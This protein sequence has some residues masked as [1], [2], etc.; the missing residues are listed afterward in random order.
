MRH[1]ARTMSRPPSF[2]AT[3]AKCSYA[4]PEITFPQ[5]T[6]TGRSEKLPP[7][8]RCRDEASWEILAFAGEYVLPLNRRITAGTRVLVQ[9]DVD[10]S[11]AVRLYTVDGGETVIKKD[12]LLESELAFGVVAP[13]EKVKK[14][15]LVMYNSKNRR[16]TPSYK[17]PRYIEKILETTPPPFPAPCPRIH[18]TCFGCQ[19]TVSFEV[20]LGSLARARYAFPSGDCFP[21]QSGEKRRSNHVWKVTADAGLVLESPDREVLEVHGVF[22]DTIVVVRN[23]RTVES[24]DDLRSAVEIY[25]EM[26]K[27]KRHQCLD[28]ETC[29]RFCP[30]YHPWKRKHQLL[31]RLRHPERFATIDT[32]RPVYQNGII[33]G[34]AVAEEERKV[35]VPADFLVIDDPYKREE[36]ASDQVDALRHAWDAITKKADE[37]ISKAILG[38]S[39]TENEKNYSL[40]A[41]FASNAL[42]GKTADKETS[43]VALRKIYDYVRPY[44]DTPL[45]KTMENETKK[46]PLLERVRTLAADS[47]LA[48]A[49]DGDAVVEAALAI[50]IAEEHE[51]KIAVAR[52]KGQQGVVSCDGC[53]RTNVYPVGF[54]DPKEATCHHL[55][56]FDPCR[57]RAG[58]YVCSGCPLEVDAEVVARRYDAERNNLA[59]VSQKLRDENRTILAENATLRRELERQYRHAGKRK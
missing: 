23:A 11:I 8:P 30:A 43:A 13:G 37:A 55:F 39:A 44:D 56:R 19:R 27:K 26:E 40:A 58:R 57:G 9:R 16:V 3:C 18:G 32:T 42:Y 5:P 35:G 12:A 50:L 14:G 2:K 54:P 52:G 29:S 59:D 7:C 10:G 41:W 4:S 46:N 20:K 53:G 15:D 51:K 21:T 17:V 34:Y 36:V 6:M 47:K 38:E 1:N 45:E 28:Q 22:G 49:H 25:E 48:H 33:V 24:E 31:E